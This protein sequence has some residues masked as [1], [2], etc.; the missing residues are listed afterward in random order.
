MTMKNRNKI[1]LFQFI[2]FGVLV[3]LI[4]FRVCFGNII[5]YINLANYISMASSILGVYGL[6]I[7]KVQKGRKQNICKSIFVFLLFLF[8]IIGAI[9]LFSDI[10]IPSLANDIFTLIALQFCIC[11]SIYERLIMKIFSLLDKE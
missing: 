2:Y 11:N 5:K 1:S 7:T 4:I 6:T 8:A 10:E 9:L 3:I